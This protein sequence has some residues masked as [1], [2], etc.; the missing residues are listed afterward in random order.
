MPEKYPHVAPSVTILTKVM[1]LDQQQA[2]T[3]EGMPFPL[4][5]WTCDWNL[6]MIVCLLEELIPLESIN[7]ANLS[8]SNSEQKSKM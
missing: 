1:S 5:D 8:D 7:G 4:S 3:F 2:Y 6:T